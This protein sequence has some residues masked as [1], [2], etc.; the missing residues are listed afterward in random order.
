[1]PSS[2]IPRL[3]QYL[4][5]RTSKAS[6]LS[7]Y[8]HA[9]HQCIHR[10]PVRILTLKTSANFRTRSLSFQKKANTLLRK[11]ADYDPSH[12]SLSSLLAASRAACCNSRCCCCNTLFGVLTATRFTTLLAADTGYRAFWSSSV[13]RAFCLLQ[14][15]FACCNTRDA[16]QP[17]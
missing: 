5:F 9:I 6:K 1:M 4:Y 16:L 13:Q 12:L 11:A 8:A 14:R 7:T 2:S 15:A 17:A 3:R 10:A